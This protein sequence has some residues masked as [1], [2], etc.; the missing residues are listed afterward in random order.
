MG[1]LNLHPFGLQFGGA[2]GA[3]DQRSRPRPPS[4]LPPAAPPARALAPP[5]SSR[6]HDQPDRSLLKTKRTFHLSATSGG[7]PAESAP[8]PRARLCEGRQRVVPCLR[9]DVVYAP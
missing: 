2:H 8:M 6:S 4:A 5:N 3:Q 7:G 9:I 1:G